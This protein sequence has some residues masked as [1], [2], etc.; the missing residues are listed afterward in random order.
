MGRQRQHTIN[1]QTW[2]PALTCINR[3][4]KA[5]VRVMVKTGDL[6][7]HDM[8]D[9]L[10]P[11]EPLQAMR[12]AAPYADL[13]RGSDVSKD[14]DFGNKASF[15]LDFA[16][17]GYITPKRSLFAIQHD[18]KNHMQFAG[19]ISKVIGIVIQHNK[20]RTI[21]AHFRNKNVTPGAAKHYWPTLQSLLPSDHAF[22]QVKGDRF[23]DVFFEQ[24]VMEHLR[25]APEIVAKGLLCDPNVN[26]LYRSNER[27]LIR[28]SV[29]QSQYFPLFVQ[30]T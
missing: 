18:N 19:I 3:M 9:W 12:V 30:P 13:S 4:E 15:A 8:I 28:M 5:M 11:P 27:V 24:N 7:Y 2:E 20:L 6:T 21:L 14:F 16:N 23:K 25:E 10:L 29:D 22:F 26:G 1:T 17:M